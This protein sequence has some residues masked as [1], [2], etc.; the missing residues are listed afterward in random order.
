MVHISFT[1]FANFVNFYFIDAHCLDNKIT[2]LEFFILFPQQLVLPCVK[3]Q[4]EVMKKFML[5]EQAQSGATS[6]ATTSTASSPAK[7][8]TA[9]R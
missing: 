5:L 7:A 1:S 6:Q 9:L 8:T 3:F 2:L 4:E